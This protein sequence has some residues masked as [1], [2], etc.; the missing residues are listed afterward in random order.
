MNYKVLI[1]AVV[2]L[3]VIVPGI[4]YAVTYTAT[5][6]S[7]DNEMKYSGDT[8]DIMTDNGTALVE[9]AIELRGPT[10]SVDGNIV[11]VSGSSKIDGYQLKVNSSKNDLAVRCWI[12]FA[13]QRSWAIIESITLKVSSNIEGSQ[14]LDIVKQLLV[15]SPESEESLPRSIAMPSESFRL[16]AKENQNVHE[17][18]LDITFKSLS[19]TLNGLESNSFINLQGSKLVFAVAESDPL[20]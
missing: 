20:S 16:L 3:A 18:Q 9:S 14:R 8:I 1:A 15:E 7:T 19:L 17:F 5:T 11:T 4:G 13:D 6:T 10:V 12:E 2:I